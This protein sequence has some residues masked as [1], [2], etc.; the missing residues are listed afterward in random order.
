[1]GAL[2]HFK[3]FSDFEDRVKDAISEGQHYKGA[4]SYQ[5]MLDHFTGKGIGDLRYSGSKRYEGPTDLLKS[6]FML[7]L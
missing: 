4:R 5:K 1:M 7:A 3:V 6:G 2:L